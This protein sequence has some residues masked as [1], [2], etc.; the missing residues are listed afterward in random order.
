M[1]RVDSAIVDLARKAVAHSPNVSAADAL[2]LSRV[3]WRAGDVPASNC[4]LAISSASRASAR[5]MPAGPYWPSV[6]VSWR[7]LTR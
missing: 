7:P 1:S 2:S 5:L 3:F 4:F 6:S